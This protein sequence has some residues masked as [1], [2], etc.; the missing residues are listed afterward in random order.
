[1]ESVAEDED[2]TAFFD[3]DHDSEEDTPPI[4]TP[5][6]SPIRHSQSIGS[7]NG[8]A[9]AGLTSPRATGNFQIQGAIL[10]A[11]PLRLAAVSARS[12]C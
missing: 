7:L 10:A 5:N 2:P 6:L 11:K 1:M 4:L 3:H 8:C 12:S 9:S